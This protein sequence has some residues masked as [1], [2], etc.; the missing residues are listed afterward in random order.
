VTDTKKYLL[1]NSKAI[2]FS[3]NYAKSISKV[4]MNFLTLRHN[5]ITDVKIA[6][7]KTERAC[8]DFALFVMSKVI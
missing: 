7:L 6:Q 1:L 5:V 8:K 3:V 4:T 2:E